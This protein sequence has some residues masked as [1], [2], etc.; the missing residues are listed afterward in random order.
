MK[1]KNF[2]YFPIGII[3]LGFIG[4]FMLNPFV[5][6]DRGE[7]VVIFNKYSGSISSLGPG[8]HFVWPFVYSKY[9]YETT[10]KKYSRVSE[11][12][13]SDLQSIKIRITLN[14]SLNEGLLGELHQNMGP[15][16][17]TKVIQP[18]LEESIKA[19][20]AK[21]PIANLITERPKLKSIIEKNLKLNTLKTIIAKK[22]ANGEK[23]TINL[24]VNDADGNKTGES[25]EVKLEIENPYHI[26]HSKINNY[27]TVENVN[28]EDVTFSK[29]YAAE[30]EK[31]EI[32]K[33][34]NET[35][36]LR[37]VETLHK[38]AAQKNLDDAQAYSQMVLSQSASEKSIRIK[39]IEK[40]DG[41]LPSTLTGGNTDIL[42]GV[43]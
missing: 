14:Y 10:T 34:A 9:T 18:Q 15:E 12:S 8:T 17:E 3:L 19:A 39:W 11:A 37:E 28:I 41:K 1:L 40:W 2:K 4:V 35:A 16:Y 36:K 21:F 5:M 20:T 6:V 38:K 32:Q 27:F 7:S 25:K 22:Q 29:A 13:T 26:S 43:K 42:L 23:L 30:V 24:P 33:Q 31:K